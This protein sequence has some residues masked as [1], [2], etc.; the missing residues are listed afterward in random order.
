[1]LLALIAMLLK[2]ALFHYT[3]RV[4]K[5][6]KSRLLEANAW[7]TRSDVV[8]TAVD[9]VSIIGAQF[10]LGW[11]DTVAAVIVGLLV[12]KVGWDLLWESARELVDTALPDDALQKMS[13]LACSVPEVRSVHD[14]RTRQSAGSTIADLHVVLE[15]RIS[16]S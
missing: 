6:T 3:M 1:M 15:P 7:H 8:S 12:G 2:E 9:L 13:A 4:A 5:R 14:L 11:L 10:G 16:V